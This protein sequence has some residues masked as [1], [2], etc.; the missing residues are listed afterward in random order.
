MKIKKLLIFLCVFTSLV[1]CRPHPKQVS[2]GEFF[3][4]AE[5]YEKKVIAVNDVHQSLMPI[6]MEKMFTMNI[7][8]MEYLTFQLMKLKK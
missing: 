5:L 6:A 2:Y 4:I 3:T 7:H 8:G 1:S